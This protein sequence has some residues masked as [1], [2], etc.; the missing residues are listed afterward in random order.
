MR[1]V[2][3]SVLCVLVTACGGAQKG[4]AAPEADPWAGYQGT[5]ADPASAK[6][7]PTTAKSEKPT[8]SKAKA[9]APPSETPAETHKASSATIKGE[10]LS[11]IGEGALANAAKTASKSKVVSSKTIV[12]PK[13]EEVTVKLKG[14]TVEIYRAAASPSANGPSVSSPTTKLG[15]IAP[16]D[17]GFYDSDAD[18]L[19]VV[20]AGKKA[21]S[22]KLLASLVAKK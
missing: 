8:P 13:Y 22:E 21:G 20:S 10:S 1:L 11:T 9:E 5:F 7:S 3:A 17:S 18:V 16:A 15:E 2:L 12:G 4:A 19:V 6:S 14:V